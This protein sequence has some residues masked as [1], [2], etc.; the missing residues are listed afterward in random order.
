[1]TLQET[2]DSDLGIVYVGNSMSCPP[3]RQF[4]QNQ[5]QI[6]TELNTK[7]FTID[8][9]YGDYDKLDELKKIVQL[10]TSIPQFYVFKKGV[11]AK[12]IQGFGSS[13][14]FINNIKSA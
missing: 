10:K 13:L 11:V 7:I 6:E 3:C 4:K 14:I 9:A 1:M 12:E 5:A 2:I 8:V